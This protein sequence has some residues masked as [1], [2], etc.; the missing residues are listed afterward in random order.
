[1]LATGQIRVRAGGDLGDTRWADEAS[2]GPHLASVVEAV[3]VV[4]VREPLL[5]AHGHLDELR[6]PELAHERLEVLLVA[7]IRVGLVVVTAQ[8]P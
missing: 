8:Q 2:A 4:L 6:G 1:M 5:L 7:M 3:Q